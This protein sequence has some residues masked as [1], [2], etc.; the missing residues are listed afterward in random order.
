MALGLIIIYYIYVIGATI[1][2]Y[3]V[4]I[5]S[6]CLLIKGYY[7]LRYAKI[8]GEQRHWSKAMVIIGW[9]IVG[10]YVLLFFLH[11]SDILI[12]GNN[13]KSVL[14]ST[15]ISVLKKVIFGTII[16]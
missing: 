11:E 6:I 9:I 8:R 12:I 3:I 16:A 4:P 7:E 15:I 5:C 1:V 14:L 13:P 2:F 10:I